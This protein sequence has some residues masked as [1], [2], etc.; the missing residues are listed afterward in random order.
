MIIVKKEIDK[1]MKLGENSKSKAKKT[2]LKI[3]MMIKWVMSPSA[4]QR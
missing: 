3:L 1:N 2:K 4:Q